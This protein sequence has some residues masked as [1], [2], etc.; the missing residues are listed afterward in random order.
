MVSVANM[1]ATLMSPASLAKVKTV[2]PRS[3]LAAGVP[4]LR[5]IQRKYESKK[6]Y[7]KTQESCPVDRDERSKE[8]SEDRQK[9]WPQ[10]KNQDKELEE[11][12][13][14]SKIETKQTPGTME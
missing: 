1:L 6:G 13:E 2:K 4:T 9:T 14:N 11:E 8:T 5:I 12:N 3:S 7:S 10:Q